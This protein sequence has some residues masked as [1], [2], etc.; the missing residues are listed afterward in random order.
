MEYYPAA[1]VGW[2]G[3]GGGVLWDDVGGAATL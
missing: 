1:D 2:V 3:V